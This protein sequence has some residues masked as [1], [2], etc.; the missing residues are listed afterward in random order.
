MA[1]TFRCE[2]CGK[3]V[4]TDV[5]LPQQNVTCPW[6]EGEFLVEDPAVLPE[7]PPVAVHRPSKAVW[8]PYAI[9]VAVVGLVTV[10]LA[11]LPWPGRSQPLLSTSTRE[12]RA[13]DAVRQWLKENLPTGKWEEIEWK[14]D[15][16]PIPTDVGDPW[17]PPE[18]PKNKVAA[19][20]AKCR[21]ERQESVKWLQDTGYCVGFVKLRSVFP[22]SGID[23]K[24]ASFTVQNG[25]A[26]V[27]Y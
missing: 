10:A 11:V 17:I 24:T 12:G 6:C 19:Y 4:E 9:A 3:P 20:I 13:K 18:M 2:H 16:N 14:F 5:W 22:W 23:V 26:S 1:S 25:K 21:K 27:Q 15:P 7:P 8:W